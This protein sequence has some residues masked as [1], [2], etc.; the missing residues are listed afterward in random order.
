[1]IKISRK[2][3]WEAEKPARIRV[4]LRIHR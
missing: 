3:G 2:V 1:M 4:P